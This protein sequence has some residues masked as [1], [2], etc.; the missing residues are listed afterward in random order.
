M[1]AVS[2]AA[3]KRSMTSDD[4]GMAGASAWSTPSLPDSTHPCKSPAS[5]I[6]VWKTTL[7]IC[8]VQ[9][10]W[11]QAFALHSLGHGIS[12]ISYGAMAVDAQAMMIANMALPVHH[13]KVN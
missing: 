2:P 8:A 4:K 13:T 6:N 11:L 7:P 5:K 12:T 9:C 10:A 1:H 3:S